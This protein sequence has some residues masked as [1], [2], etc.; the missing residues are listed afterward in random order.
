M[1][2]TRLVIPENEVQRLASLTSLSVLDTAPETRFD[3]RRQ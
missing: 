2:G 3:E 1:G